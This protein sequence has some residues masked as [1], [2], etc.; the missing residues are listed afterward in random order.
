MSFHLYRIKEIF[1][2]ASGTVQFIELAVGSFND[3]RHWGGQHISVTDGVVTHDFLF[4][5][6]LPGPTANTTVLIATQGF[7]DLGVVTPDFIVPAGFLFT[8]GGTINFAG[9]TQVTYPAL[10]TN[11]MSVDETGATHAATPKNFAGVTV[12][13]DPTPIFTVTDGNALDNLLTGGA[14]NDLMHGLAGNDTLDGGAGGNDTL[15]GG[16]GRDWAVLHVAA[17]GITGVSGPFSNLHVMTGTRETVLVDIERVRLD[18]V[19]VAFDTQ[20]DSPVWRADALLWAGLGV[21]PTTALLSQWTHAADQSPG[22]AALAQQM[23]DYY[24]PGLATTTLVTLL[25]QTVLSHDATP[26]EVNAVAAMVGPGH[27]FETNGDLF[28]YVAGLAP[29]TDKMA[30]FVGSYQLLDPVFF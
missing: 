17:S 20:L 3:E 2:N 16:A 23:L 27:T 1:S 18:N 25:Y 29:N 22:M 24:A 21:A 12:T 30:G 15:D 6:D 8:A 26:G 5:N 28:A 14:G 13:F 19:I 4:P 11:N 9:V 10:P 7:A